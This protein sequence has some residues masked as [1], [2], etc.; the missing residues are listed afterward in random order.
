ML[1]HPNS[2]PPPFAHVHPFLRFFAYSPARLAL[3]FG[4][5]LLM[6]NTPTPAKL[7]LFEEGDFEELR[8]TE[9]THWGPAGFAGGTSKIQFKAQQEGGNTFARIH[10]PEEQSQ[11]SRL[12]SFKL[13]G[14]IAIDPMWKKVTVKVRVR[15]KSWRK[16]SV[17]WHGA[18]VMVRFEDEKG[19]EIP[20]SE[21]LFVQEE[22]PEWKELSRSLE[23][24]PGTV[25][26]RVDVTNMGTGTV[27]MDDVQIIPE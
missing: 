8:G 20:H 10:I 12:G 1:A 3:A 16:N 18:G 14:W 26:L 6:A 4:S 11:D 27:D 24:R 13:N 2:I 21:N 9:F 17:A 23:V 19:Q 15:T 22:T 25:L 5:L 7:N